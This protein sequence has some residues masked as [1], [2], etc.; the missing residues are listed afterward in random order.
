MIRQRRGASPRLETLES[1]TLLSGVTALAAASPTQAEV[2]PPATTT[3]GGTL[4]GGVREHQ[5]GDLIIDDFDIKA[6]GKLTPI[7]AATIT[8]VLKA[9]P[10]TGDSSPSGILDLITRKGTLTLDL[11]DSFV[12]RDESPPLATSPYEIGVTYDISGGTGAYQGDTGTGVVDFDLPAIRIVKGIQAG[13][14]DV[15]FTTMP[16]TTTT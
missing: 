6:A 13:R 14:A 15:K 9:Y 7:G 10:G 11:S 5:Q 3:L 1:L 4:R 12:P 2:T 16:K 8:G